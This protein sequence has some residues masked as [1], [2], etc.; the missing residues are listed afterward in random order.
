M[1]LVGSVWANPPIALLQC[2]TMHNYITTYD[3]LPSVCG[4][5]EPTLNVG[6]LLC[7]QSNRHHLI[8]RDPQI[9]KNMIG[10]RP[11][12]AVSGPNL[13][14]FIPGLYLVPDL[15]LVIWCQNNQI[16]RFARLTE[17]VLCMCVAP[18]HYQRVRF[19]PLDG[20]HSS[21]QYHNEIHSKDVSE[22][23]VTAIFN[24][25][26]TIENIHWQDSHH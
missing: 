12:R 2:I 22:N 25:V 5:F 3:S 14:S 9:C 1:A 11:W 6:H 26:Q 20:A 23:S 13:A 10:R 19:W 7:H 18:N 16:A 17:L 4:N 24:P 15:Y 8:H 21:W